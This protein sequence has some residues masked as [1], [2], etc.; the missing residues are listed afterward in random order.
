MTVTYGKNSEMAEETHKRPVL[1]CRTQAEALGE[2]TRGPGV[3]CICVPV[4][5]PCDCTENH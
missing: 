5:E 2:E 3:Q 1:V 4:S